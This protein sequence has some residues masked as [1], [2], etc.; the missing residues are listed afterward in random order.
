MHMPF[1]MMQSMIRLTGNL[2]IK[3][4]VTARHRKST[5]RQTRPA[6]IGRRSQEKRYLFRLSAVKIQIPNKSSPSQ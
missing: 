5:W 1:D 3:V 2:C 6:F 4:K